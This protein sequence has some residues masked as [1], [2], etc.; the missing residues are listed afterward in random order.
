MTKNSI[1]YLNNSNF[2]NTISQ[3]SSRRSKN[4]MSKVSRM[5]KNYQV[6]RS[7]TLNTDNELLNHSNPISDSFKLP[8]ELNDDFEDE[9][10]NLY[11]WTQNLSVNDEFVN[12]PR[13]PSNKQ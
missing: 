9:V 10:K 5:K 13:W 4:A 3:T 8:E 1:N 6:A 2:K 11:M 7:E 12:S